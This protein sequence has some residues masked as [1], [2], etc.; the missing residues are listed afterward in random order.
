MNEELFM[1]LTE[2]N[3]CFLFYIIRLKKVV[4]FFVFL[5]LTNCNATYRPYSETT[6]R[7]YFYNSSSYDL[8]VSPDDTVYYQDW[9]RFS[10]PSGSEYILETSL[11]DEEVSFSFAPDSALY[12]ESY[13]GYDFYFKNK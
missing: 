12:Y 13:G 9:S 11:D 5:I 8:S 10:L 3:N 4:I 1:N 7:V 6:N 2:I